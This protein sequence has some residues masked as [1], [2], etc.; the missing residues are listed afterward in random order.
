MTDCKADF[1]AMEFGGFAA[2][3]NS[4]KDWLIGSRLIGCRLTGKWLTKP[5]K[6]KKRMR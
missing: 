6:T 1:R 5:L 4:A 3:A 2:D